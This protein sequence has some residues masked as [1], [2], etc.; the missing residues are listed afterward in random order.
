MRSRWQTDCMRMVFRPQFGKYLT[1]GLA[2]IGAA[3]IVLDV[4]Q[5]GLNT[6]F[7]LLPW[8]LLVVGGCWAAYWRPE[9][10]VDDSGVLVVNVLRTITLPWPAIQRI[11]TKWALTLF[12][13]YGK[14]TAWAAPAPG[15]VASRRAAGRDLRGLPESTYGP[16]DSVRPGDLPQSPS[17]AAALVVRRR[18][19]ELRDAGHLDNP[20][21]EH[22]SAPVVWHTGTLAA[23]AV[24]VV[25]CGLTIL[26]G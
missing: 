25:L 9:V 26:L 6:V 3:I 7:G 21:L 5:N 18:W 1:I 24:L 11:D 19:E 15:L 17:G 13:A 10:A 8:V 12:T 22:D 23:A 20:R 4:V 14:F 2:L 16:G